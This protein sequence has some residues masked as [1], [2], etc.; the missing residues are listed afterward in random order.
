MNGLQQVHVTIARDSDANHLL[1]QH[2]HGCQS[3]QPL[4]DYTWAAGRSISDNHASASRLTYDD[5]IMLP[6][7]GS[8]QSSAVCKNIGHLYYILS[9]RT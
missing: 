3:S 2:Y 4:Q 6:S 5:A 8:E 9:S 1:V 7:L